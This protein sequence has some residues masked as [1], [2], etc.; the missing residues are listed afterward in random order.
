MLALVDFF[1]SSSLGRQKTKTTCFYVVFA[2]S[3]YFFL[4]LVFGF[5]LTFFAILDTTT[6]LLFSCRIITYASDFL[7]QSL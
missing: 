2:I 1:A 5:D 7:P 4:L 6:V 3:V